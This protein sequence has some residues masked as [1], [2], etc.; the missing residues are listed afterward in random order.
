MRQVETKPKQVRIFA[1]LFFLLVGFITYKL[2]PALSLLL[3]T[4][5]YA[6]EA[7]VLVISLIKPAFFAPVF[8]IA[9][10]G[11]GFIGNII[12]KIISTLVFY[13]ILTP[14]S[15]IMRLFGKKFL[16]H[17][18]DPRAETYYEGFHPHGGIEKQF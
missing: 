6:A 13:L 9:L 8:K 18:T 1:V 17:K 11:S 2:T 10:I 14:L 16:N 4:I 3:K 15:L 7:L 5:I 12:F